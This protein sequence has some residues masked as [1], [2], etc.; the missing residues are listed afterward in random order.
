LLLSL[1]LIPLTLFA[2]EG[3]DNG[4]NGDKK[5]EEEKEPKTIAEVT[6]DS[7]RIDGLFTL[8]RN[9]DDGKVHM[10][11]TKDQVDKEFIYFSFVKDGVVEGGHFRGA[12]WD[13][14]V[15]SVRRHFDRIEFVKENTSFWFNPDSA[16]SR[17]A[18]ANISHAILA[19]EEIVA[20]DDDKG[21]YLISVDDLFLKENISQ[22]KPSPDPDAED[23][24]FSLGK[25]S[26]K[27]SKI[28]ELRNY[29]ENTD[30]IVEYVYET[31]TPKHFAEGPEVTDSR[32]VSVTYQHS[33]IRMP[34][35]DFQPRFDDPRVGYFLSRQTDLTS[36]EVV[37][38]RD[39]ITR[40]NLVKKDPNAALSEPVEPI[41]FWM[42][43]TTPVEVRSVIKKAGEAWNLAFEQA[44]FRNA[45]VIKQQPDDAEWDAGD[46]R[47]NVLRWTSSPTPPFGGYG[48]SFVNPRT[49]Q[50][51]GADIM[52]E[53]VFITNRMRRTGIFNKASLFPEQNKLIARRN[54]CAIGDQLHQGM[55][56]GMSA[57]YAAGADDMEVSKL[58]E[59]G[60]YFLILHEI[61]HTLGLNHNMKA[62]QMLSVDGVNDVQQTGELG[63]VG[64][65]MDYP[66][67][68]YAGPGQEQGEYYSRRPGPYDDWAIEFGYS[69]GLS[70]PAAEAA[71]LETILARSTEHN[72]LFGNDAD[73]MRS[74][75][76]GIDPRTMVSDMSSD[77]IGYAIER[78]ALVNDLIPQLQDKLAHPD[79]SWQ[80]VLNSF[81]IV[82]TEY[83]SAARTISRHIGGVYVDRAM[84]GQEGAGQ[85]FTA[86]PETE[87]KRAMAALN[88]RV[89]APDAFE[90]PQSLYRHLQAQR[91][92]FDFY[93]TTEDPKIHETVLGVQQDIFSFLLNAVTLQRIS[94]SQ[95]YGNTYG[96]GEMMGDLTDAVFDA[97]VKGDVNTFRQNL[98]IEYVKRLIGV[99]GLNGSSSHDYLSQS[100]ALYNLEQVRDMLGR[101]R[102]GDS[103]TRAHTTHVLFLIDKA[104]DTS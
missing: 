47:Y 94:D 59:D 34:E 30:V 102:G 73:D 93:E 76:R 61:G 81:A 16:L 24:G 26:K 45:L 71:R 36:T 63:V 89:F 79:Q 1:L 14:A 101:K 68:N 96:L 86:V 43:N 38:Y 67:I 3:E 21:E 80:E 77:N 35:N 2:A 50:I 78:M 39:M 66:A 18:N 5:E 57:A 7:E 29:P 82:N 44:G 20:K 37:P 90:A 46:I 75:G 85:P 49:G 103:G 17:S 41:V 11:I 19:V 28:T 23:E 27:K 92:G 95:L 25:L 60:L 97:D 9:K 55:L 84:V 33:L 87:Q 70:D 104:L 40:W 12:F 65:I 10:L 62:S 100:A 98:Q 31:G 53:F 72:L 52:L 48:P 91:R 99:A 8:F 64:S 13:N 74:A 58:V 22:V 6:E 51:I 32:F 83:L 56:F 88:E 4:E 15:F 69:P 54:Y 42:E